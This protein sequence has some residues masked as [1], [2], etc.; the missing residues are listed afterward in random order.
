MERYFSKVSSNL[1]KL[2]STSQNPSNLREGGVNE[3]QRGRQSENVDLN[4]LELDPGERLAIRKYHPN[5][6]DAIRRVV[7][8]DAA[9]CFYCYLFQDECINQGGGDVFST[10]GFTSWNKKHSLNEHVGKPN[11]VHNQSRQNCEDLLRQKQSIQSVFTKPTDQQKLDYCTRLEA[12][13]NVLRYL[14]KQRLS[15]RGHREDISSFNRGNYIELLTWYAKLCDNIGGS[16]KKAPKNNQLTSPH[17][18]KDIISAFDESR[19]VSCKE[20]MAIVLW[21]VDR[22]GSVMERF[23]GIVHVRDTT[24]LSLKKGIVGLLSQHSLSSSYI[25]GQCYDRASNMQGDVNGLKILMQQESKGAHSIHCFA[26]Q[27]QL[28]L[29]AIRKCDEVK[30][31]LLLVSDILNMVGASFKRRDELREA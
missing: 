16:F 11:S 3:L 4:S 25:R 26:H 1:P 7:T 14:L 27:L 30:E 15:F 12:A 22:R 24:A 8:K 21:Y 2:S 29:V 10:I 23:I 6:R 18:Q 17:I 19:D 28:T 9:F 20:Q 31:L 5:D 13:I